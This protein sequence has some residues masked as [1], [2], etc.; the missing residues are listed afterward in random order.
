MSARVVNTRVVGQIRIL[1]HSGLRRR[2]LIFHDLPS[3]K[4]VLMSDN[5]RVRKI[6]FL[7]NAQVFATAVECISDMQ[8]S[9]PANGSGEI[10]FS[11]K[12]SVRRI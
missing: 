3:N 12:I 6:Y 8:Y 2:D 1:I 10:R 4:H 7:N 9:Y 11:P 5:S